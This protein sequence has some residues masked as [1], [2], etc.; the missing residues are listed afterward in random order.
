LWG[1]Y[2]PNKEDERKKQNLFC[3]VNITQKQVKLQDIGKNIK[4]KV[5][6]FVNSNKGAKN[7]NKSF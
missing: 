5:E 4:I 3:G 2:K 6:I 7:V 1:K